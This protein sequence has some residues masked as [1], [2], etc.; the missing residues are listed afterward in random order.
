[1]V[2]FQS[3]IYIT[4]NKTTLAILFEIVEHQ[5]CSTSLNVILS[6]QQ[7]KADNSN[8]LDTSNIP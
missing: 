8:L 6:H 7:G 2:C 4:L 1:M 5:R 3:K